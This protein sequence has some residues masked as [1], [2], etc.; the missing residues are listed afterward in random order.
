M[1]Q[2]GAHMTDLSKMPKGLRFPVAR[3]VLGK[4]IGLLAGLV[5]LI[6]FLGVTQPVFLTWGN[7]T[8]IAG[9]NSVVLI[10]AIGSTF[11]IISGGIDLSVAAAASAAGMIF[12]LLL[13]AG[14]GPVFTIVAILIVGL[15]LGAINGVLI[16]YLKISFLVVTLGTLAIYESAALLLNNGATI[17]VFSFDSFQPIYEFILGGFL[18]IPNLILLD[19]ALVIFAALVLKFSA[20]GRRVYAIGSNREA[21]RLNGIDVARTT[22]AVYMIS[23]LSAGIASIVQV[24]R[25]TGAGPTID[26]TLLLTVIAAVL[27]GGTA[28]TGGEGGVGGTVLGVIFLG[29]IQNA[30]TLSDVSAFWRGTVN[31]LVLIAAVGIGVARDQGWFSR[32]KKNKE[33]HV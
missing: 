3:H 20:F 24:G 14:V 28:Y 25:L 8:N 33:Q 27:I 6:A 2:M 16:S 13:Q 9:S 12:G 23:G 22:L 18:G 10:L 19:A 17:N 4:H 21:A 31:G 11:V 32:N 30:L 1:E 15:I 29:A 7:L 26:P 5:I